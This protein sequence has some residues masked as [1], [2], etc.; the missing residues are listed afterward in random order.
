MQPD[1]R[2]RTHTFTISFL[3]LGKLKR[4]VQ[5]RTQ[6]HNFTT[7]AQSG[8]SHY[9]QHRH[10]HHGASICT[11][12]RLEIHQNNHHT[13]ALRKTPT[14]LPLLPAHII[15]P[16]I[17]SKLILLRPASPVK[18]QESSRDKGF[19]VTVDI[20]ITTDHPSHKHFPS[21]STSISQFTTQARKSRF[22]LSS[23]RGNRK[24]FDW[25]QLRPLHTLNTAA[26]CVECICAPLSSYVTWHARRNAL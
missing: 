15:P 2:A 11:E 5:A 6:N 19:T 20:L 22:E 1:A 16:I 24:H 18:C 12:G 8:P 7:E 23:I 14:W 4:K 21:S 3:F 17:Q 26:S 13:D 25:T 10:R 9:C